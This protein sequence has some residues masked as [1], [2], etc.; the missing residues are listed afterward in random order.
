MR[1]LFLNHNVV[2]SGTFLRAFHFARQ[3][4]TRGHRV[5][6]VTTSRNARLTARTYERDGVEMIEAPDLLSG[7]ARTGWDPYNTWVRRTLVRRTRFD[8]VHAFDS[9]PA[10]VYPALA[11]DATSNALFIMDWA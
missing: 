3:L 2:G 8:L 11:A 9:R 1:V 10:V 4:A 7:R 6:L 5:T